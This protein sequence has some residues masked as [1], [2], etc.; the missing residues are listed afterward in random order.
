MNAKQNETGLRT[1][2]SEEETR[3]LR[4]GDLV[5]IDGVVCTLREDAHRRIIT[6]KQ[7]PPLDLKNAV[8]LHA[9]PI[10]EK[11]DG[12]WE[13]MLVGT[14]SCQKMYRYIPDVIRDFGVKVIISGTQMDEQTVAAMQEY[15]A[16]CLNAKMG[17][18][19]I[20][21]RSIV[22]VVGA[23]WEDLGMP[24][25]IWVFEVKSFGPLMVTADSNGSE[26]FTRQR[27]VA[28]KNLARIQE[29]FESEM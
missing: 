18:P 28:E 29:E 1:P 21:T 5:Y 26:L 23:F 27:R 8:I 14:T 3:R 10:M 9:G 17:C 25:T 4:I 12:K 16:V 13:A 19:H 2:V 6:D 7:K 22:K 24:N 20:Y 15:G 11:V